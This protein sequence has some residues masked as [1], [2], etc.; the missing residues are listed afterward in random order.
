MANQDEFKELAKK[1]AKVPISLSKVDFDL[2][3]RNPLLS[4]VFHY[5]KVQL[6]DLYKFV[7]Q[8]TCGWLHLSQL[9]N[10]KSLEEFLKK[11]LK[12]AEETHESDELF[13]LLDIQTRLGRINLRS[14]KKYMGEDHDFLWELMNN[15]KLN[16][17]K[18]LT[19]FIERWKGLMEWFNEKILSYSKSS[20]TTVTK[21]LKLVLNMAEESEDSTELPLVSH[22]DIFRR[23][24]KPCYRIMKDIDIFQEIKV[25]SINTE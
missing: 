6:V 17:K 24:Y 13:E 1:A 19:L 11:E 12:E 5:P 21:W 22:S 7:L 16:S 9:G 23:E 14:W 18:S 4:H 8:G 20:E 3:D 15:T 10:K 25:V 2:L